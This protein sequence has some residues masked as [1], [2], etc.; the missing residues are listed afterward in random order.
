MLVE[1]LLEVWVVERSDG[2][3]VEEVVM[4][5]DF[6]NEVSVL[7][8]DLERKKKEKYIDEL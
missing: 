7:I 2:E 1:I 8:L 5:V 4:E 3:Y 6:D